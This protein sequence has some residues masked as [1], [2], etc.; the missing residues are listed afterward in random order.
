MPNAAMLAHTLG[1]SNRFYLNNRLKNGISRSAGCA[2]RAA[3]TTAAGYF[4]GI[5]ASRAGFGV[6]PPFEMQRDTTAVC[7]GRPIGDPSHCQVRSPPNPSRA[8]VA[9]AP[10][11]TSS[12]STASSTPVITRRAAVNSLAT[13]SQ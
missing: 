4:L 10:G 12:T 3:L 9:M 11:F 1:V 7:R 8:R 2:Q 5:S 13:A 6:W